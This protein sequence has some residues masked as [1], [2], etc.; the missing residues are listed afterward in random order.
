MQYRVI[1]LF[2]KDTD[3]TWTSFKKTQNKNT[4]HI[5]CECAVQQ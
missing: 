5:M 2:V 3:T 4:E 1:A